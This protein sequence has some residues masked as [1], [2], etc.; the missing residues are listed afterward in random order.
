MG[1][2]ISGLLVVGVSFGQEAEKGSNLGV[3]F[4]LGL[5]KPYPD[6]PG[7]VLKP[8][9]HTAYAPA[10]EFQ[11][12]FLVS[13]RFNLSLG[14]GYGVVGDGFFD[15][16]SFETTMVYG[17]LKANINLMQPGKY[18]PYLS[19]GVGVLNYQYAATI[20]YSKAYIKE[21]GMEEVTE[22]RY[23][24]GMLIVG[25]GLEIMTSPQFAINMFTDYR[26]TTGDNLDG[27][28][29]SG[30]SKDGY[31]NMRAGFTYYLGKRPYRREP[32]E[33]ELLALQ[34]I[35]LGEADD[36][37]LA[38]DED[39]LAMFEAKL[40]KLDAEET[41]FTMEQYVRLKSRVDELNDLIDKKEMEIEELR[42]TL[43]LKD[44]RIADL[45]TEL[46]RVPAA[47]A[48]TT[49]GE[50]TANYEKS[51]RLFYERDYSSAI[52][53]LNSLKQ[54]Y[55]HHKLA[56]NCQYWI[57]ECYFAMGNY[58]EASNAFRSVFDYGFSYK[59]DDATL[60][61][62]RCYYQMNDV[63]NAKSQWNSLL[64]NYPESE[65]VEKARQWLNRAG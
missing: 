50:F 3:G 27:G 24:D 7:Y 63:E 51:L 53:M 2:V 4:N 25:G 52:G 35:E 18:N 9:H 43:E 60:M 49:S 39:N 32:S 15:K 20:D 22:N 58:A 57:G 17:D 41:E 38:E 47:G 26:H 1:I 61:L 21:N 12:K 30:T 40:D 44:Q 13:D 33:D 64:T 62:G 48:V 55:P 19:L 42:G 56:S 29:Y 28:A 16:S 54:Q 5:Q 23:T 36:A 46:Q 45:Q 14:V 65:Y 8:K 10:G 11:T 37:T 6:K 59:K 31:W 34:G